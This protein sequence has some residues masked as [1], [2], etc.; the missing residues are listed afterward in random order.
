ML[1]VCV[2]VELSDNV[3]MAFL[4]SNCNI[5]WVDQWLE[6]VT[7]AHVSTGVIIVEYDRK[8]KL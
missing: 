8:I 3:L 7:V 4:V 1:L 6:G 5:N 2:Y